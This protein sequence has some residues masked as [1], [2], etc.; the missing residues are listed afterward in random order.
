MDKVRVG[1]IGMGGFGT[2]EAEVVQGL[3]NAEFVAG[4][5]R[6]PEARIALQERFGVPIYADWLEMLD[7]HEFD[8]VAITATN[9]THRYMTEELIKR[10]IAVHCQKPMGIT[11]EDAQ[12]MRDAAVQAGGMRT[13]RTCRP[14]SCT[15]T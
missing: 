14:G 12:V 7:K 10:G 6:T 5:R 2:N 3:P 8:L 11:L 15:T 9:D 4:V 13:M 1:I